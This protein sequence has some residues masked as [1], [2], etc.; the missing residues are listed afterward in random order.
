MSV[1]KTIKSNERDHQKEDW[2]DSWRI[3]PSQLFAEIGIR[4]RVP[5]VAI[6]EDRVNGGTGFRTHGHKDMEIISYVLSGSIKHEDSQ[7]GHALLS[8]GEIQRMTAGRGIRHS[9]MNVNQNEGLHFLQIWVEP[10]TLGLAP[11]YQQV[12]YDKTKPLTL[13]GNSRGDNGAVAIHQNIEMWRA[14]PTKGSSLKVDCDGWSHAWVQVTKGI[15]AIG[16]QTLH[17]GDSS[18]F[19]NESSL[20][21]K[22]AAEISEALVFLMKASGQT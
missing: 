14:T 5:L 4:G 17:Q 13:L 19:A 16:E 1:L 8:H 18:A 22:G 7:G 12:A 6:A 10:A 9:E 11:G 20:Q 2:L 21:I 15:I 3:F